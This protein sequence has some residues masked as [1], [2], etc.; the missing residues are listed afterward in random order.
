MARTIDTIAVRGEGLF[1]LLGR[2]LIG[3]LYIPGGY[4]HLTNLHAFAQQLASDGVPGPAMAWAIVGA[5]IEFFAGLAVILGWK[6]RWAALLLMVFTV[7]ASLIGHP[8]WA[9]SE[10]QFRNQYIHFSKNLAI[11][12]GLLFVF[13]RG[14]GPISVDGR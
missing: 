8:F 7:V 14:P 9:A 6:T 2:L 13:V 4:H 12:G 11:I 5:L 3:V 1:L 10:G